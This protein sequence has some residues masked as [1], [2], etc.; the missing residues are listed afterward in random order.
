MNTRYLLRLLLPSLL[1]LPALALGEST[2]RGVVSDS[3]SGEPLVGANVFIPGTAFGAVTDP[4]GVF[5]ISGIPEGAITVR[6]SYIG[7][8]PWET[9]VFVTPD[10]TVT[11][12]ARLR[13]QIIEG[14]EIVV[15]AQ[16]RGQV[17][18]INQQIHAKNIVNVVSEEKI[19][20]LPDANAAEAVGRLPGVS[21]TRSGGEANKVIIRGLSD[22]FGIITIDGVRVAAT[23]SNSRG[24]DLST[25]SQGS[26]A[27]IELFKALTPD[28]D[29]DAIAG[30]VNLVTKNAPSQRLVRLD[31]K[32]AYNQL[33]GK[34]DQ[35]D[36]ALRYGER[37]FDNV[38][39]VQATANIER[40]NRSNEN[41]DL[42]HDININNG[43]SYYITDLGLQYTDE[44][45]KRLGGSLLFDIT[46]PDS[47]T[48]KINNTL[49]TT[50]RDF[51]N[52]TRNYPPFGGEILY[53]ARD[54]EQD[55]KTFASSVQGEQYPFGLRVKWGLSFAQSRAEFPYDFEMQFKEPSSLGDTG[56]VISGMRPVPQNLWQGPAESFV[57][58][59]ANNFTLTYLEWAFFR[60]QKNL[61]REKT[62]FLD[63][64]KTLT[65]GSSIVWEV[66]VGA[67]YRHKNR[68][69]ENNKLASPYY[70]DPL[71]QYKRLSDGSIVPKSFQGTRFENLLLVG[72]RVSLVNFLDSRPATRALYDRFLLNP[73]VN[74]D[75]LRDWYELNKSGVATAQG[76]D[77]EY[78]RDNEVDGDYYDIVER[79]GAAYLMN[80]VNIGQE[81]TFIGGVRME[82]ESNDYLSR[83]SRS[84]LTGFPAPTGFLTDT[85][86]QHHE[87]VWLPNLQVIIRPLDFMNIRLAAYRALARPDFLHRLERFVARNSAST[88][89]LLVGNPRLRAARAWAYEA[90]T[91]FFGEDIGL[92][93]LAAFYRNIE[94]MFH[95]VNDIRLKA[96]DLDSLGIPWGDPFGGIDFNLTYPYNSARPTRVWGFEVE[97][98]A[99]LGFLPG[100]LRNLVLSYNLTL[101]RSETYVTSS[102][103]V[104][105]TIR[106]PGIPFPILR[107]RNV[108]VESKERLESQ[109]EF[110]CNVALG[111]DIG[112]FSARLSYYYQGEFN[113]EF[114]GNSKTDGVTKSFSRWDL[115][116][117]QQVTPNISLLFNVNNILDVEEDLSL[118]NRIQ[119]WDLLDE[120]NRYGMSA[121]LG[122]RVTL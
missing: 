114:S 35:Y 14:A 31:G 26:L 122:V 5:R 18:A 30:T 65:L 78:D 80:T 116:V 57:D 60:A 39:G 23:D 38:L 28:M 52:F 115:A 66:K 27:G 90:N 83:F 96:S 117:K 29:G 33:S 106:V 110:F 54:R 62:A 2:M 103:L 17:A 20:E 79:I 21:I 118:I 15:T 72:A 102:R 119:G 63:V 75:A 81:L 45:R 46:T 77:P 55:I 94:G 109:P 43:D 87:T 99:N 3:S 7:F 105:D 47:G 74:G 107:D 61:D 73:L 89:E 82:T 108:L 95:L 104:V 91:S 85:S 36:F 4:N 121:D 22:R 97:H 25:I 53:T 68:L 100:L 34:Y 42:D 56:Q 8:Q 84:P 69:K 98:Q 40:R 6:F 86:A 113:S 9:E 71:R 50:N 67:K 120:S 19:Q 51:V 93:T 11:L 101:V 32:G 58:Y 111:Y 1:I 88:V 112:G 41:V 44:T 59:A 13:P 70:I 10:A 24:V 37:F 64:A 49:N 16:M 12:H 92:L 48:I 76:A